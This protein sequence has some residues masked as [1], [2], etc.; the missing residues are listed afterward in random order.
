MLRSAFFGICFCEIGAGTSAALPTASASKAGA[1]F[2]TRAEENIDARRVFVS[3][4][5]SAIL[6][7]DFS[8]WP[9]HRRL[10]DKSRDRPSA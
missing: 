10:A 7:I 4:R 2:V 1:F 6:F 5:L 3:Y 8:K 9:M